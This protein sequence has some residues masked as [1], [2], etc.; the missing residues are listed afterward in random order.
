MVRNAYIEIDDGFHVVCESP[1]D[2]AIHEEDMCIV[3]VDGIMEYGRVKKLTEC[4]SPCKRE[5]ERSHVVRCATLQD[6]AKAQ[7]NAL[8]SKMAA[9]TSLAKAKKHGLDMC[10]VR[11]RYSFDRAALIITFTAEK[12]VDFREMIKE[13]AEELH[14]RIEMKQIGVRD[15]AGIIGGMGP[16]GRSLCCCT[17]LHHFESINAKTAKVQKLSMNPAAISGSCGRLRCC[18]RFEYDQYVQMSKGIPRDGVK[19]ECSAGKGHVVSSNIIAQRVK[20]Q[21]DDGRMHECPVS[22]L[23]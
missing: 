11:V 20:V 8:M 16:C 1:P 22:E 15:E 12:R 18:L 5:G 10:L 21:L 17:W 14:A 2:L 3:N 4:G 19:V 7:E 9:E 23:K 13:L 6:Q